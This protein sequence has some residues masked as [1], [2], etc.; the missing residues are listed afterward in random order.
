LAP[1]DRFTECHRMPIIVATIAL[2]VAGLPLLAFLQFDFNPMNLR[3]PDTESIA[4]YLDLKSDP[5]TGTNAIDVLA[6]SLAT[7]RE[8]AARLEKVPEVSRVVTVDA[9]I[10]ADQEQKLALI[11]KAQA[12]LAP[13]FAQSPR[14]S[15]SDADDVTALTRTAAFLTEIAKEESG[16]GAAA[17]KRLA[18]GS[19]RLPGDGPAPRGP[20]GAAV[21]NPVD[22]SHR[23]RPVPI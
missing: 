9:F 20:A 17:A 21:M 7:A 12:A 8:I 22:A 14:P 10:P 2:V 11:R 18:A 4:T 23:R 13:A 6:P 5:Q 3:N 19:A 16:P 15:P 1:I